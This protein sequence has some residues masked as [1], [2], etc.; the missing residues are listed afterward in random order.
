MGR[1]A[2]SATPKRKTK[3]HGSRGKCILNAAGGRRERARRRCELNS[4]KVFGAEL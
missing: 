1:E 2:T 4:L 3:L